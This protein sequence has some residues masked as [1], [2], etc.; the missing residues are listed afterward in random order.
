MQYEVPQGSILGTL[1]FLLFI[2]DP[3]NPINTCESILYADDTTFCTAKHNVDDLFRT[4]EEAQSRAEE[5]FGLN[6]L[7]LNTNKT[8]NVVFTS[9]ITESC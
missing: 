3:P 7:K 5:W 6:T 4:M 1:L 9:T 8:A 2:N